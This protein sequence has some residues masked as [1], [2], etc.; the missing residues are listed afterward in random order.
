VPQGFLSFWPAAW[1]WARRLLFS[2]AAFPI[3]GAILGVAFG[4]GTGYWK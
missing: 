2:L 3:A 4:L 1:S